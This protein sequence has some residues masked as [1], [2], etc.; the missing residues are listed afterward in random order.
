M[1]PPRA[2]AETAIAGS[3]L[4]FEVPRRPPAGVA[5]RQVVVDAGQQPVGLVEELVDG[6]RSPVR[7]APCAC[8]CIAMMRTFGHESVCVL[9]GGL[10]QVD[11]RMPVTQVGAHLGLVHE[12]YPMR[13]GS[14]ERM[15][16]SCV[17]PLQNDAP[18][19]SPASWYS[20]PT[21]AA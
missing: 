10:A 15:A 13:C 11:N 20:Q 6:R 5:P 12:E 1:P 4:H 19:M 9:E 18:S 8:C 14:R 2:K 3:P 17:T 21:S 16:I 7:L